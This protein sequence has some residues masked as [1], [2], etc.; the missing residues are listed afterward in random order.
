MANE[1]VH[2]LIQAEERRK[3]RRRDEL[4]R[5]RPALFVDLDIVEVV[6]EPSSPAGASLRDRLLPGS[7]VIA[8]SDAGDGTCQVDFEGGMYQREPNR[9]PTAEERIQYAKC[10]AG[11]AA[12]RYPTVAR[13]YRIPRSDLRVVG[14]INPG[15]GRIVWLERA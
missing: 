2:P 1:L 8:H 12:E 7:V 6:P 5:T 13:S 10:A 9:L 14:S 3:A 11:R 15:E 4:R